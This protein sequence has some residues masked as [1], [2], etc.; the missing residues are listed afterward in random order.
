MVSAWYGINMVAIVD[1]EKELFREWK[2]AQK[3]FISDGLINEQAYQAASLRVVLAMKDAYDDR[4]TGEPKCWNL[5]DYIRENGKGHTWATVARWCYGLRHLQSD[6]SWAEVE[7][8][9]HTKNKENLRLFDAIGVMNMKKVPSLRATTDM[10]VLNQFGKDP[11]NRQ[12][13]SRQ[14]HLYRPH[15]T[16]CTGWAP[17][18]IMRSIL[19]G[20][21]APLSYTYRGLA[22]IQVNP[23]QVLLEACHPAAQYPAAVK[24]YMVMDAVREICGGFDVGSG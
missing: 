12:F 13:L 16:I 22:Y 6:V 15:L 23:Q 21:D 11:L 10:D 9:G 17:F 2:G 1:A 3:D 19:V 18:N 20:D 4:K 8:Y 5:C 14:W 24:Y 7:P